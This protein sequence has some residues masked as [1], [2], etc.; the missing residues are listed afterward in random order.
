MNEP[1]KYIKPIKTEEPVRS[2]PVLQYPAGYRPFCSPGM[3][4]AQDMADQITIKAEGRQS[5]A[6]VLNRIDL[7][8]GYTFSFLKEDFEGIRTE[9]LE[10]RA[11][12]LENV[13]KTLQKEYHI[14]YS[15]NGKM[16]L[17]R[18]AAKKTTQN[19]AHG[20]L[21]GKLTD[22]KTGEALIGAIVTIDRQ[23][24]QTDVD[25]KFLMTLAPGVYAVR[26]TNMG[27]SELTVQQVNIT[28]SDTTRS[29]FK[30]KQ[31]A[32]DL[33]EVVVTALGIKREEKALGYS[34]TKLDNEDVT[35]AMSN[36]WTNSMEGKVAGL[37]MLKSNGGPA[38]TNAII[39]RGENSLSGNS[40]ALIVVDG[41]VISGSSGQ[42]S[43]T[44]SG[45]YLDGDSPI[46][47]GTS[48][49]DINP[50]DIESVSVLKG[51]GASALY[52]AR[53][54]NGAIVITTKSGRKQKGLGVTFNSNTTFES[55]LQWPDFQ[56]EYGQ[57]VDGSDTWY[58]YGQTIDGASTRSTSS[59]WGPRFNG[60]SYFQYNPLTRTGD[61]V[62][63]PRVPYKNNRKD[64]FQT[65]RTFTNT[66][67][68]EGGNDK[69]TARLSYTNLNNRWIVPNTGYSR[70]TVA[71]ALDQHV[72][73]RLK[74]S[75][76]INYTN[77]NSDNLP[78]TGY[79]NQSIMYFIRGLVPNANLNW[80]KDYWAPGQEQILQTRPFSSLLDNPYLIANEMLNKVSRNN[81]IGNIMASYQISKEL[82]LM[83]RT[84]MD[85][86]SESRSQQRPMSSQKFA[87]G[88]YRTQNIFTQELNYDF[89][90]NYH[91]VFK[92][93]FCTQ[94][95]FRR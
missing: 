6:A 25:G 64:F 4:R 42:I 58:S 59:A 8:T 69:T 36:N 85:W 53:G 33:N 47:F 88:M 54:A 70:N 43:G 21:Q 12:K 63:T 7:Q 81:V 32:S 29:H 73:P 57:G 16:I 72:T 13:L 37:N 31:S 35:D 18:I 92:K 67:T 19:Q 9:P 49:N 55:I 46:D 23:T 78:T 74:I 30:L 89:L 14:E 66:L 48:L 79:N 84:T 39:L 15:V 38:G 5:L 27:Y 40:Q 77:K 86:A 10:F 20:Y 11:E 41:V 95:I 75:T 90:L 76:H 3:L 17:L 71:L 68:L 24:V 2:F 52:G 87:S 82:D 51:P 1:Q 22:D 26:L 80:F 56:Y 65:A 50:D 61:T 45:A 83:V 44:G 34:I 93:R 28:S 91:K 60:Q 62:R 94:C